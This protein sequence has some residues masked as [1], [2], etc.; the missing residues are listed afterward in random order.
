ML[1]THT[2]TLDDL[3]NVEMEICEGNDDLNAGMCK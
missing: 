1:D 2:H 3:S